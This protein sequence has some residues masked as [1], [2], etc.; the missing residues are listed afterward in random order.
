MVIMIFPQFA[1]RRCLPDLYSDL[2]MEGGRASYYSGIY[3]QSMRTRFGQRFGSKFPF[4]A[5]AAAAASWQSVRIGP[6]IDLIV[7]RLDTAAQMINCIKIRRDGDEEN[8]PLQHF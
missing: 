5:A 8:R 3:R 6:M 4:S 2:G 7:I 1:Q